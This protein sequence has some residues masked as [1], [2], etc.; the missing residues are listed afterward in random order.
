MIRLGRENGVPLMHTL[1][2]L[3]YWH[4]KHLGDT[5]LVAMQ[6]RGRMQEGMIADITIFN[7]DTITE[8]SSMKKGMN[9][10]YTKGI[11]YVL[12]SGEVN[13]DDGA[14][15]TK[16]R[17]GQP[18]RYEPI[19]DAKIDLD[20]GDKPFQWHAEIET[21]ADEHSEFADRPGRSRNALR[22]RSTPSL[23]NP[24]TDTAIS[25]SLEFSS[26]ICSECSTER[27]SKKAANSTIK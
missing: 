16:L 25:A 20:L 24:S 19:K 13:I 6:E 1:A 21:P 22:L 4:A 26:S 7:P 23:V 14:A 18:I 15:N 10:S 27:N 5:G 3:S 11:P 9:G 2:Q 12:V 17:P 8:T